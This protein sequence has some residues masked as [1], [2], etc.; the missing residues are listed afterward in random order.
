M[1]KVTKNI[2]I[3]GATLTNR[4][5]KGKVQKFNPNGMRN[6]S[7]QLDE[8]TAKVLIHDG[9]NVSEKKNPEDPD[10]DPRYYMSVNVGYNEYGGPTII[11]ITRRNGRIVKTPI[12]VDTVS[13]L[14]SIEMINVD[15]ELR[16]YNWTVGES[17]GVKAYLKTMYYELVED[18]FAHKYEDYEEDISNLPFDEE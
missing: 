4:N 12:T 9:W 2:L 18:P 16:P 17:S 7:V 11:Q 3:E 5:F 6:F 14:D 13:L 1:A 10:E 15:L 8:E